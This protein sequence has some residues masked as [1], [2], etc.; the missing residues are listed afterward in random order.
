MDRSGRAHRPARLVA[1][2]SALALLPLSLLPASAAG[3]PVESDRPSPS[4]AKQASRAERSPGLLDVRSARGVTT[5][6]APLAGAQ[7]E[8]AARLGPRGI[9]QVDPRTGSPRVVARL[10]GFLTGP[11]ERPADQIA[12]GY[13]RSNLA[14]FGLTAADL[15]GFHLIRDYVDVL[16]TH[17]LVWQQRYRG[18]PA[19]DN[20]LRANVTADGRLVNVMGSP[21]PALSAPSLVPQVSA[22]RAVSAT[23]ASVGERPPRLGGV[24]RSSSGPQRAVTYRN[25]DEARLVLLGTGRGARLAWRTT[26][27]VSSSEVYLSV[28]D[29][30]DREVLWRANLV[31]SDSTG[32]GLAWE[33]Y[34]DPDLPN[35]G[36]LQQQVPF[37][38]A[39]ATALSG[40][41]AHVFPDVD[42]DDEPDSEVPASSGLDWNYPATLDTVD[43][44]NA[45]STAFPCSW[46]AG[47]PFSWQANLQQNATQVYHYLNA[48]H[49]HLL[50][51]PIGFTEAAGNFQMSNPSG[52][53]IGGDPVVANVLDGADTGKT[54]GLPDQNHRYNANML[55]LPDGQ[56]PRMQMYLFPAIPNFGIPSTN[57]GDDASVV[58]H[59]YTHGLSNRLVT[60]ADGTGALNSAQAGAMGEAWSDFYA[61]DFLVSRGFQVDTPAPDVVIGRYLGGG[62]TDF[63]RFEPIDCTVGASASACPGGVA[64]GPG[65]YTFGDFGDVYFFPQVHADGEIWGQTLWDIRTA[66]GSQTTLALVTRAMELAPPEPSFLDMR[67]A[68]IQA[69]LV[70]FAGAHVDELWRR[71]AHRGMGFF[72]VA[73]GGHDTRPIEDFTLPPSCPGDCGTVKGRVRDSITGRP[74]RGVLV[75]IA[76]HA[77]G[78]GTDLVGT[79]GADGR[80]RIRNVPFHDYVITV[81]SPIHEP[82]VVPVHVDGVETVRIRLTR[83]WAAL[84]G[85]AK[86]QRFTGPDY[87]PACGPDFAFDGTLSTG[88]GSDHPRYDGGSGTTGPRIAIVRLPG[89]IDIASFG[90]ASDGTCGDGPQAAVR[91]FQIQTR[92]AKGE[93]WITAYRRSKRLPRGVMHTLVPT[94]GAE[95]VRFVKMVMLDN[96]GDRLFMDMLELSVRGRPSS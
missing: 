59:E 84:A 24:A 73:L 68:I 2:L 58:Y 56:P 8:L 53:G 96:Y 52:Q 79:T 16:G 47:V 70:A 88:W 66:L 17:H 26:A 10:D 51:P 46:K 55:T 15:N 89:R 37:P 95:K 57:G 85:G 93:P 50:A 82:V 44:T 33:H 62:R 27:F 87:T 49:D 9:L 92:R 39:G 5:A 78:F 63:I 29:A 34:P 21:V 45:C 75:Q 72:A 60:F 41:N 64:T 25:G 40:N 67:N 28:V 81:A 48:F 71:F 30:H 69:D 11:S 42:D 6:P 14:A 38:V 86:L 1:L 18:V 80:Y 22:A 83:D 65:G 12:L 61:M 4:V 7:R 32:T 77:S 36:G 20:D 43:G 3:G 74:I 13:V 19:F 90:F 76:G 91:V 35:G 23:Y 31:R 54:A 94:R